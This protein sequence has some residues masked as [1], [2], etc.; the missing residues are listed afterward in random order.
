MLK[1]NIITEE[2]VKDGKKRQQKCTWEILIRASAEE[3]NKQKTKK[4]KQSF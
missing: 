3:N 4:Q 1:P 2:D